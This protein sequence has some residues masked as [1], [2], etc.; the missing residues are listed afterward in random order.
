VVPPLVLR[1]QALVAP[2]APTFEPPSRKEKEKPAMSKV[3]DYIHA[4]W[5]KTIYRDE[6]GKG[7]RGV[8]LPHP[9]TSPC[10]KGL[11]KFHFFFYWDA[12]FTNL[13]LLRSGRA[14]VAKSNIQNMFW[15]IR[16]QGYMPNHV[17]IYNRS[18]PPYLCRMVREY[19]EAT[20][21]EAFL[22]ECAD[23][24][25]REYNF[26]MSARFSPS[27]LNHHGQHESA[28]G[29]E[30]FYDT[31]LVR[32]LGFDAGAPAA[33]KRELGRHYLAEAE[34]G[35][36]FNQR[37]EGR[38]DEFNPVDLNSLLYEYEI[39]LADNAEKTGWDD[40]SIL[41]E[42]AATR[43]ELIQRL[44]WNEEKG[45]FFDY[46][47]VNERQSE[48][49]SLGGLQPLMTGI[50]TPEQAEQVRKNLP[51]FEREQGLAVTDERPGCRNFQWAFPNVW[52]P[53]VY[54]TMDGLRRY[55]FHEDAR[56]V[57]RKYLRVTED[58]F[59]KTG[60]LWEKT[61][62]ETGE[63]AGGE[64]EAAPMLGW[65]AGVYLALREYAGEE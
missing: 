39:W 59:E 44:L 1:N 33:R 54:V 55:G 25:R 37:F 41:L 8:D 19:L 53:L 43:K 58:L 63:I 14:D 36:D 3:V 5:E 26:W 4:N 42:R 48:T 52:P 49:Q 27:G 24:L 7:F 22:P 10:V 34:T 16:R 28:E 61:D 13:G 32:R 31:I 46:D 17:G 40:R 9:Y 23:G 15:L 35:W 62:A 51:L 18:Q 20:G 6:P 57:A 2:R 38:C 47:Y 29:Q 21:D 11:G 56:R 12:Y 45:W 30:K 64:Y 60:Q 65:T 50:A